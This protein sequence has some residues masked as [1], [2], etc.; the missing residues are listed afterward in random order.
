MVTLPSHQPDSP[1]VS[2]LA[3]PQR[4]CLANVISFAA[5]MPCGWLIPAFAHVLPA[6]FHL[7][8]SNTALLNLLRGLSLLLY[9]APRDGLFEQ[10]A[11]WRRP[12]RSFRASL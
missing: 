12:L 10:P 1:V 5:I 9:L 6:S 8:R 4:F 7:M 3:V 2:I 11:S